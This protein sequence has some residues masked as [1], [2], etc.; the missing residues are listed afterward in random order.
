MHLYFL[1]RCRVQP[2][3]KIAN[4]F[5]ATPEAFNPVRMTETFAE[6]LVV[7]YHKV[8][9]VL[10]FRKN[11]LISCKTIILKIP[12]S[13]L[14]IMRSNKGSRI[15]LVRYGPTTRTIAVRVWRSHTP[16]AQHWR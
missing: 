11:L 14:A 7:G 9:N 2:V 3:F 6:S 1:Y 13:G 4:L 15:A 10:S 5:Q 12:T 16:R 8:K